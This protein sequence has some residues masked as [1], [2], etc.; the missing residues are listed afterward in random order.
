MVFFPCLREAR[1]Q[2]V[3][4]ARLAIPPPETPLPTLIPASP[5]PFQELDTATLH[6]A[7]V[8]CF[9]KMNPL[10]AGYHQPELDASALIFEGLTTTNQF[11]GAGPDLASSIEFSNDGLTYLVRFRT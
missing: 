4:P 1:M 9:K 7:V 8:G 2:E 5:I 11:G 3:L 6:E 10:L